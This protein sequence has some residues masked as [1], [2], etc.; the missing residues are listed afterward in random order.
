MTILSISRAWSRLRYGHKSPAN[1]AKERRSS[2][3]EEM[4]SEKKPW[5]LTSSERVES[6]SA[7]RIPWGLQELSLARAQNF[8]PNPIAPKRKE[9]CPLNKTYYKWNLDDKSNF[10]QFSCRGTPKSSD[11]G[12]NCRQP[13]AAVVAVVWGQQESST[14]GLST[15]FACIQVGSL[16]EWNLQNCCQLHLFY[17]SNRDPLETD[18]KQSNTSKKYFNHYFSSMKWMREWEIADCGFI[19]PVMEKSMYSTYYILVQNS[20]RLTGCIPCIWFTSTMCTSQNAGCKNRMRNFSHWTA[21]KKYI[22]RISVGV[23]WC[24]VCYDP[25]ISKFPQNHRQCHLSAK[26]Y[27][28]QCHASIRTS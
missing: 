24:N 8:P 3:W 17:S 22:K 14:R 7:G 9:P 10:K 16:D 23:R 21:T 6:A 13:R 4:S 5:P 12:V 25:S 2:F 18:Q 15:S 19:R 11:R 1:P 20:Q 26:I 28:G 27:S